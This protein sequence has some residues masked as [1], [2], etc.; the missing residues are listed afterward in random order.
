[1]NRRDFFKFAAGLSLTPPLTPPIARIGVIADTQMNV[2]Q[3]ERLLPRLQA[4]PVDYWLHAG[5][6]VIVDDS[7]LGGLEANWEYTRAWLDRLGKPVFCVPGNHD[8]IYQGGP[9][10]SGPAD[11][12]AL[13]AWRSYIGP[14]QFVRDTQFVRFIGL[15]YLDWSAANR[16]WLA[17]QLNTDKFTV[18]I[19]HYPLGGISGT[20]FDAN[21]GAK[22]LIDGIDLL[23]VGHSHCYGLNQIGLQA[24]LFAPPITRSNLAWWWPERLNDGIGMPMSYNMQGWLEILCYP[25][26]VVV[27]VY[28]EDGFVM[29]MPE[30]SQHYRYWLP[31]VR[32]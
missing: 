15:N 4:A 32:K 2:E 30:F 22:S 19:Q 3:M 18:V 23:I 17:G 11:A 25:G 6:V 24:Q 29:V 26:R 13:D 21:G 14:L 10:N 7:P 9:M 5:D 27:Q 1:M 28:R 16:A 31:M 8:L 20:D 12:G